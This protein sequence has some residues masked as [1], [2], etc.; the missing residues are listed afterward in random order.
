MQRF[1]VAYEKRYDESSVWSSQS[2]K[3]TT[4]SCSRYLTHTAAKRS[5]RRHCA[6]SS[7]VSPC[8]M[9]SFT[10]A[11]LLQCVDIF[12]KC[13][14]MEEMSMVNYSWVD[15]VLFRWLK[16]ALEV[17]YPT[18]TLYPNTLIIHESGWSL[19]KLVISKDLWENF[20]ILMTC[21][22]IHNIFIH[23]EKDIHYI[24]ITIAMY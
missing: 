4:A 12:H 10:P 17:N 24:M 21:I 15:L 5:S 13:T 18:E 6:F 23:V 16:I 2:V 9:S 22:H 7:S 20:L 19:N 3:A 8:R 14:N 11:S 1:K